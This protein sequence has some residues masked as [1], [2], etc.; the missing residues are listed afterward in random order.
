MSY[1]AE[2]QR[3]L[4][5]PAPQLSSQIQDLLE[6][7]HVDANGLTATVG[8]R[9][10]IAS[11]AQTLTAHLATALYQIVH[12]GK[13]ETDTGRP[14]AALDRD[15]EAL[16]A[17]AVPHRYT[18]HHVPVLSVA[19][20]G[21]LVGLSGMRVRLGPDRIVRTDN[22]EQQARVHIAAARPMLSP[23]FFLVD[24]SLPL[25]P[26]AQVLRVYL[27][28]ETP[29]AAVEVW[30]RTLQ[31]LEERAVAYRAKATS[32]S[33]LLARRDGVVVYL[34]GLDQEVLTSLVGA[35]EGT[36]GLGTGASPFTRPL[37]AGVAVAWEPDDARSG[38]RNTSLGEHRS[39][40]LASGLVGH[41]VRPDGRTRA[42]RVRDALMEGGIDP[43][44]PARNQSS[45]SFP[46]I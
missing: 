36:A 29:E 38:M 45:P 13:P 14:S 32:S 5:Q 8:A 15:L 23:G 20:T 34:N 7:V 28:I 2:F 4:P 18:S 16:L 17:R 46:F 27:H 6:V 1:P 24:G 35:V 43:S 37:A 40:A 19:E 12:V 10:V 30:S 41:A 9:K 33:T 31:C 11:S 21:L 44:D 39:R 22:D 3:A 26:E 42:D 25:P